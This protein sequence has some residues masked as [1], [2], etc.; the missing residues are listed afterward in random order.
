MADG[1]DK[2][3]A[4]R[5]PSAIHSS[6]AR[7]RWRRWPRSFTTHSDPFSVQVGP[8]KRPKRSAPW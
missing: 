5:W 7:C 6:S 2:S 8:K 4:T 3:G 1:A